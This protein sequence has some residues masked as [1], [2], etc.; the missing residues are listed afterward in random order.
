QF[1][2]DEMGDYMARADTVRNA[3]LIKDGIVMSHSPEGTKDAPLIAAQAADA[4]LTIRGINTSFVL[5]KRSDHILISGRSLGDINVQLVLEKLGGGGH[6][7]IAGAQLE[8]IKM[9]DAKEM[10]KEALDEYLREGEK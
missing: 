4:L 3:E 8:G 9:E 7:T 6:L 10:L 5:S 2:Q 1:I